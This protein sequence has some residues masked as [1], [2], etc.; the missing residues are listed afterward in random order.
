MNAPDLRKSLAKT[1]HATAIYYNR[2]L[3]P[4]VLTMMC[5]DLEDLDA[6]SCIDAYSRW[7][8]NPANKTFPLPAQIREL[9]APEQF[10]AVETQAREIAARIM[11]SIPKFGYANPKEAQ[12]FIGPEGWECVCRAGGWRHLCESVTTKQAPIMQAQFRDQ[13]EGSLRYGTPAI[14]QSIGAVSS[15]EARGLESIGSLMDRMK[16]LPGADGEQGA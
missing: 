12:A 1:I 15:S 16:L 13:L 10:V 14:E 4:E 8:K 5:D 6:S 7:R 9:V 2:N 11:G 3:E